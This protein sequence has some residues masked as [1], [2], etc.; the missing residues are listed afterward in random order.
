[1]TQSI[2]SSATPS[3]ADRVLHRHFPALHRRWGARTAA[4]PAILVL[5]PPLVWLLAST[6]GAAVRGPILDAVARGLLGRSLG[7][8]CLSALCAG[9]L[10]VPFGWLAARYPLPGRRVLLAGSIV[11]LLL[12]PYA[13]CLA[14][15]I[16]LIRDGPLNTWLL[17]AGWIHAPLS[18]YR[19]FGLAAWILASSYW[20]LIGW[21][22]LLTA[23]AVPTAL[24]DAGRL[25]LPDGA[26]ARWAAWPYLQRALP[27]AALLVFVLSIADFGVTNT[28]G[29]PVYPVEIVNRFQ[30]DRQVGAVVRVAAPMVLLLIPLVSLQAHWLER[31]PLLEGSS[32]GMEK[33][34]LRGR[35]GAWGGSLLC[36]LVLLASMVVPLA[37]LFR[38][39]LPLHTYLA[40]WNE[41][42]DHFVN[43]AITAGGGALLAVVLALLYGWGARGRRWPALELLLTLPYALPASLI[44][45]AM[46]RLLA[47]KALPGWLFASES[48]LSQPC[49]YATLIW[50]YAVLFFP[51]VYK[52]LQPAWR[53]LDTCLLDEGAVLGAGG[54]S[55]F[56]SAAWPVL[57][58]FA[59]SG[60]V[61]AAVLA[62]REIDA[63]AL[64]R[65][66]DCDTI[67]F[68]IQDYLHFA[69]GPNVAALCVLLVLLSGI[70][71]GV[72]AAWVSRINRG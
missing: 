54:W 15:Q 46:I 6:A 65:P 45:V 66:P 23:R 47:W 69:P 7:L 13:G 56:R 27:A 60:A 41:S 44:G 55:Q 5:L 20:P 10:G 28:L 43:S 11:S 59:L 71:V 72:T 34:E 38:A 70:I 12:P 9:A 1:M 39:S 58:P 3:S 35:V 2:H 48:P 21:A 19:S 18:G 57:R 49:A 51:F 30:L 64:L 14:W 52:T 31:S 37:V 63:T 33:P 26:A 32:G 67:A 22:V 16:L 68:R 29:L 4:I 61:L 42:S 50:A 62:V 8:A 36:G 17:H 24:E 25:D 53:H 40:V